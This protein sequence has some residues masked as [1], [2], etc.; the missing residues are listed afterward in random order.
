MSFNIFMC[1]RN[2]DGKIDLLSINN[3]KV[4]ATI[5]K[6]TKEFYVLSAPNSWD[7]IHEGF[8]SRMAPETQRA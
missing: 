8:S 7:L 3:K 1:S 6:E 4:N 5:D 2:Y